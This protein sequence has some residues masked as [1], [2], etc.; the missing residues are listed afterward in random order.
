MLTMDQLVNIILA[1]QV[2]VYENYIHI[3]YSEP[4]LEQLIRTLSL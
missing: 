3:D 2:L 1:R 4:E